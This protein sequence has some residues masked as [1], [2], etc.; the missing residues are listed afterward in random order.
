MRLSEVKKEAVRL[1]FP[2]AVKM[3][4]ATAEVGV[5]VGELLRL[6]T[7]ATPVFCFCLLI[8]VDLYVPMHVGA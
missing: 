8:C 1:D 7:K 5:R 2:L 3:G 6:Y 4:G